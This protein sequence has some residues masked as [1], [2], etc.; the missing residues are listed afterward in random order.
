[1]AAERLWRNYD[2]A[3]ADTAP[4]NQQVIDYLTKEGVTERMAK[5]IAT[6][7]RAD[8]LPTGPRK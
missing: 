5:A 3:E 8:G 1:M 2:P 6:I 7:L 4:T